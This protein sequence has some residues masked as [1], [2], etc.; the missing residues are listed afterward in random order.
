MANT[1]VTTYFVATASELPA[2]S[3]SRQIAYYVIDER[4]LYVTNENMGLERLNDIGSTEPTR[5][6]TPTEITWTA[7]VPDGWEHIVSELNVTGDGDLD[8][9]G[10]L[11]QV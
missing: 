6:G 3:P 9:I 8:I 4:Q 10:D 5:L 2:L 7:T 11:V 1:H